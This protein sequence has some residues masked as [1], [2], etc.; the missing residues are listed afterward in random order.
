MFEKI[1]KI[2][3]NP[4]QADKENRE[5]LFHTQKITMKFEIKNNIICIHSVNRVSKEKEIK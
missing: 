3:E 1:N 2:D 4:S 5:L